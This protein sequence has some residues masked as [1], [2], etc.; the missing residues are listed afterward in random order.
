MTVNFPALNP[1]SR[2]LQAG[3]YPLKRFDSISGAS[4]TRLYGSKAFNAKLT[5]QFKLSD[6]KAALILKAYHESRGG[7]EILTL[8]SE[9]YRGMSTDFQSQIQSYYSWR[10][11]SQPP[12]IQSVAPNRSDVAITLIGTLDA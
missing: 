1:S 10:F 12:Q 8:P 4:R 9:L 11:D 7:S 6:D 2:S 3:Q 5:L